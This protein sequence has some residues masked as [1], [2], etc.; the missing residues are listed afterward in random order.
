M[1]EVN[2][3]GPILPSKRIGNAGTSWVGRLSPTPSFSAA[4]T[5]AFPFIADCPSWRNRPDLRLDTRGKEIKRHRLSK[6]ATPT[7]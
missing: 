2:S 5:L 4:R 1:G 6:S 7:V 3:R